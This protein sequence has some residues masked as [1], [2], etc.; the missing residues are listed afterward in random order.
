G[1]I[2]VG[3]LDSKETKRILDTDF[4]AMYAPSGYLL[5]VREAALMAQPFD[6]GRL[7]LTGEAFFVAEQIGLNPA[8][9]VS[10]FTVSD[11]GVLVFASGGETVNAQLDWHDRTGKRISQVGPVGNHVS[12][13]LSPDEKRVAVE[14]LEKGLG[15]IWLI[16]IARNI[17]SRFTV[18]PG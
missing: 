10:F 15:D 5:F 2:Y 3:S 14:R 11:S 13:W 16:D 8:S 6:A 18:D 17:P 12:L 1:G 4:K 9:R 7:E